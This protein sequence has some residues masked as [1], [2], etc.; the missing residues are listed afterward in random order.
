MT[1]SFITSTI[2]STKSR[3]ELSGQGDQS[4]SDLEDSKEIPRVKDE[5][6]T[7]LKENWFLTPLGKGYGVIEQSRQTEIASSSRICWGRTK[8][9]V[10]MRESLLKSLI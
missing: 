1:K 8:F 4:L 2:A 10:S 7:A 9:P 6:L 5:R 3:E